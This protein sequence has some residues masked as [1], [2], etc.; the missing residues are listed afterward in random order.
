[1]PILLRTLR[2]HNGACVADFAES[3]P[4][5]RQSRQRRRPKAIE[6]ALSGGAAAVRDRACPNLF[7]EDSR[8][9]LARAI[10]HCDNIGA[11]RFPIAEHRRGIRD[12]DPSGGIN[13]ARGK[14]QR[15][16]PYA[17]EYSAPGA[18]QTGIG[19]ARTERAAAGVPRRTGFALEKG[20]Q[21]VPKIFDSPKTNMGSGRGHTVAAGRSPAGAPVPSASTLSK[22]SSILP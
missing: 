5:L 8:E 13:P 20:F 4:L 17:I 22:R 18:V 12:V 3:K 15:S 21:P 6:W 7:A 10:A 11:N 16:I 9:R 19:I 2:P 1:M 14:L